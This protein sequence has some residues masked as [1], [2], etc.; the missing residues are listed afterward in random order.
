MSGKNRT[1]EDGDVATLQRNRTKRPRRFKVLLHNDDFTTMDFV[2]EILK[3]VFQKSEPEALHIMLTV[4][5]SNVG[6]AGVYPREVAETKVLKVR[7]MARAHEHP[8]RCS[9]EPEN[10]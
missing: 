9:M 7:E 10:P 5:H 2:V 1:R 4:H 3:Q 8:L 6:I